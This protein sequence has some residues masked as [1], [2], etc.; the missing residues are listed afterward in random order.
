MC[1]LLGVKQANVFRAQ[2]ERMKR[3]QEEDEKLKAQYIADG[4]SEADAENK[5]KEERKAKVEAEVCLYISFDTDPHGC[6]PYCHS[7]AAAGQ[8]AGRGPGQRRSKG[9]ARREGQGARGKH[10]AS[11]APTLSA[12][13]TGSEVKARGRQGSPSRGPVLGVAVGF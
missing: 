2:A 13:T 1:V 6:H 9:G 12:H 7:R 4:M 11:L 10:R 5:V 8:A 3:I